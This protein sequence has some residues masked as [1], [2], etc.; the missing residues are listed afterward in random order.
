MKAT[1]AHP[2]RYH[3]AYVYIKEPE[4][5]F[6]DANLETALEI[7]AKTPMTELAKPT[8]TSFARI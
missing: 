4:S 2:D 1:T 3:P 6:V 7:G 5:R 8:S